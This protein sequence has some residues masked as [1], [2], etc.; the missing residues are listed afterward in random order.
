MELAEAIFIGEQVWGR[1]L[2]RRSMRR[3]Y[4][5]CISEETGRV[6]DNRGLGRSFG[7]SS[8][9]DGLSASWGSAGKRKVDGLRKEAI[10]RSVS[11]PKQIRRQ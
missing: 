1:V 5:V 4:I 10:S 9:A 8:T 6:L 2:V 11:A 3:G 7:S